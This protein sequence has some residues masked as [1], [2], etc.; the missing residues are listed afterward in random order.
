[1][2]DIENFI[3]KCF[4]SVFCYICY[5]KLQL[6]ISKWCIKLNILQTTEY[7]SY[8]PPNSYLIALILIG[9]NIPEIY[10]FIPSLFCLSPLIH[11]ADLLR[12]ML[13]R[14]IKRCQKRGAFCRGSCVGKWCSSRTH[15]EALQSPVVRI[16][17]QAGH[18]A[19]LSGSVPAIRTV[20]KHTCPFLWN[21]LKNRISKKSQT[22]AYKHEKSHQN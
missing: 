11:L 5:F 8:L 3:S 6:F 19:H 20:N 22:M 21:C 16:Q 13:M 4:W 17:Q 2:H 10:L 1:M 12:I 14:K 18:R 9:S 7:I 15:H